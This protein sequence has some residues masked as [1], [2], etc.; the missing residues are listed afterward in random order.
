MA[1]CDLSGNAKATFLP[2]EHFSTHANLA[3]VSLVRSAF[4]LVTLREGWIT[5][6][7]VMTSNLILW[8][9]EDWLLNIF[10][11]FFVSHKMTVSSSTVERRTSDDSWIANWKYLEGSKDWFRQALFWHFVVCVTCQVYWAVCWRH[12]THTLLTGL[13][14]SSV[15]PAACSI[16]SRK[17]HQLERVCR[18]WTPWSGRWHPDRWKYQKTG[19]RLCT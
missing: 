9:K 18:L 1:V 11:I 4:V 10:S 16:T 7:F 15:G 8:P 3:Q 2:Q 12:S 13:T 5:L 14:W 6:N 19:V 17:I